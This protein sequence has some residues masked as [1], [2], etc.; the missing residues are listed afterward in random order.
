MFNV[1]ATS[2]RWQKLSHPTSPSQASYS[3]SELG[4]WVTPSPQYS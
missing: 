3:Q 2:S 1:H 4:D